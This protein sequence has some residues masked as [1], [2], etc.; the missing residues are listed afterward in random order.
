MYGRGIVGADLG[1]FTNEDGGRSPR[2]DLVQFRLLVNNQTCD[3]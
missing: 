3:F 1:R 2:L